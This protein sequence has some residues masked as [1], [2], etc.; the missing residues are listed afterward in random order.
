MIQGFRIGV[1]VVWLV[2]PSIRGADSYRRRNAKVLEKLG[3]RRIG[4]HLFRPNK[5]FIENISHTEKRADF[6]VES[7]R[8]TE[9]DVDAMLLVFRSGGVD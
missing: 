2:Q 1:G 4:A 6:G 7:I 9:V 5:R 3:H 8:A